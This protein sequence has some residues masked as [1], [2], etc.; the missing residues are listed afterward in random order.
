[1][2]PTPTLFPTRRSSDLTASA[3]FEPIAEVTS[4]PSFAAP[5]TPRYQFLDLAGDGPLDCVVLERPL[6]GF[7]ERTAEQSWE[8][9]ATL[10]FLPDRKSTRLNSSHLGIS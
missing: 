5:V 6:T 8:R 10:P 1:L 4:L 2:H 3:R 9:F 7:F